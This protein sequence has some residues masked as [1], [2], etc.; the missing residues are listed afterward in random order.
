[1][2][3]MPD[4]T[5]ACRS[6]GMKGPSSLSEDFK[7][8]TRTMFGSKDPSNNKG[9]WFL[10]CSGNEKNLQDCPVLLRWRSRC[11][12]VTSLVCIQGML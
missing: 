7:R 4:A 9:M 3:G 5:V 11:R 8:G 10:R 2:W 12:E 1:M 6:L